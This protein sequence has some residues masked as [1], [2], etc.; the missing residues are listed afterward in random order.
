VHCW[1]FDNFYFNIGDADHRWFAEECAF[2]R[3]P[4]YDLLLDFPW[5][6]ET[7]FTE[8]LLCMH[9]N[10]DVAAAYIYFNELVFVQNSH[11][12]ISIFAQDDGTFFLGK[13][14]LYMS[15]RYSAIY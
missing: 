6:Y 14:R 11:K 15:V 7:P 10:R 5:V 12:W 2:I 1:L 3:H 13:I 8:L 9:T 4:Y